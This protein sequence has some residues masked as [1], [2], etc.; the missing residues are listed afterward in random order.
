MISK[1][2]DFFPKFPCTPPQGTIGEPS[3]TDI[4]ENAIYH[5]KRSLL[6][7]KTVFTVK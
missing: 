4:S 6:A 7:P 5:I 1:D 2:I 3:K